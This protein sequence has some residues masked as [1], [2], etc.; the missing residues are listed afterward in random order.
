MKL[1]SIIIP[2]YNV[3][4]F[5]KR[6]LNSLANQNIPKD[7]YEIICINDG[8]PDNSRNIVVQMQREH[9]NIV[10]I[11]QENQGVSRAR[12]N[13]IDKAKGK[14]LL[15]FD[16]DDYAEANCLSRLIETADKFKAEVS[17][18]G[19]TV[20]NEDSSVRRQMHSKEH[21]NKV[22][23]GTEAYFL[24]RGDGSTDPDRVWAILFERAFINKFNLRYLP[25]VPYLEDGEILARILCLAER[26]IFDGS[27]FYLRT[28]R[29]GSATNSKLFYSDKAIDGFIKAALNLRNFKNTQNL[30][31]TQKDFLNQP[32]IKFV[33]LSLSSTSKLSQFKKFLRVYRIFKNNSLNNLDITG[34]GKPYKKLGEA[35]NNSIFLLYLY[36]ISKQFSNSIW[37]RIQKKIKN[38]K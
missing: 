4:P 34:C 15:F 32:L 30:N 22:Y 21:C 25:D 27:S 24:S 7:S 5:L 26:C 19:F 28:I 38:R 33:V 9:D 31:Q 14:Y 11:D 12:N 6:C 3:E 10:L 17:F 36:L 2:I 18:L 13:G 16:P 1:L 8:S 29:P 20:L 23:P 37:K 35:Y